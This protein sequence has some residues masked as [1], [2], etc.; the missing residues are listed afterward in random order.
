[1]LAAEDSI[2]ELDALTNAE[3]RGLELFSLAD[4]RASNYVDLTVDLEMVL[5]G[6]R[7]SENRRQLTI[8][9]LEIPADGDKFLVTFSAPKAIK[10]TALLSYSHKNKPDDQWLYLPAIKR[11]KKIASRNRSGP[12][13]GSEFSFEDLSIQE[14]EKYR[15]R[16]IK[17]AVLENQACFVV[18]RIP[19]DDTSGYKRHLVWLDEKELNVLRIEYFDKADELLKV[20]SVSDYQKYGEQF[21]KASTML[22]QNVQTG[23]STELLWQSYLFATGLSAER[24]FST[25]SLRRAR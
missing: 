7:G 8:K 10:G 13:L 20:L 14:I 2:A 24:D 4:Q 22:M 6:R 19:V 12:F 25:N 3:A 15:Y 21:W 5:R 17:D 18:E 9:Q 1:V 11:V 16:Y 23:R